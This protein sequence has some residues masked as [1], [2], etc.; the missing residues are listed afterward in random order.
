VNAKACRSVER[1]KSSAFSAPMCYIQ[2]SIAL[3]CARI[4]IL[5]TAERTWSMQLYTAHL[6]CLQIL[7]SVCSRG[8]HVKSCKYC[9]HPQSILRNRITFWGLEI[10]EHT[11]TPTRKKRI[12]TFK[13]HLCDHSSHGNLDFFYLPKSTC[14]TY[15]SLV[16]LESYLYILRI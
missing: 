9:K 4:Y 5:K 6:P 11:H 15:I 1:I 14:A 7:F 10:V 2:I 13:S 16:T 8:F 3:L 12:L